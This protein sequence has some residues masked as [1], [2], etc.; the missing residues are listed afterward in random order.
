MKSLTKKNVVIF[1]SSG[2]LGGQITELFSQSG[3][4]ILTTP[5]RNDLDLLDSNA[6]QAF[7]SKQLSDTLYLNCAAVVGSVH[8]GMEREVAIIEENTQINLNIFSALSK[9]NSTFSLINF[10]SNCMYPET[11]HEQS[12]ELLFEGIPHHTARAYA[13]TKRHAMQMFNVLNDKK[14]AKVYQLILPGLFGAGNHLDESRLHAFDAIIVRMIKAKRANARSF[15]VYGTGM[16]IREWV[17]VSAVA[18]VVSMIDSSDKNDLSIFNFSV[19]FNESIW[20]TTL[21]VKRILGYNGEIVANN[22]YA[23]GAPIKI[24]VNNLFKDAYPDYSLNVDIDEEV[25][26]SIAYYKSMLRLDD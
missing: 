10:L 25:R 17:P 8:S 13:H 11:V 22:S 1:G 16:P 15:E 7:V 3:K 21:R 12:E 23:D 26:K 9:L 2:F 24:L 14:N 5:N 18:D 6:T 19:G 20:D 4:Y